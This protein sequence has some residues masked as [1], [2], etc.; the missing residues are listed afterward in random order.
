MKHNSAIKVLKS[1]LEKLKEAYSEEQMLDDAFN[2][3]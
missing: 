2:C 1:H 3:A